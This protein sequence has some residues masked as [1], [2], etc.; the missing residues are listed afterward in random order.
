MI[1]RSDWPAALIILMY[2]VVG[3]FYAVYTPTW[4]VPD[5]PA[6]YNY[7]RSF[8]TGEGFPVMEAG[9]YDQAYLSRLTSEQFPE[10]LPV[11]P[12]EYE[13]H[14]PPLYYLLATPVF[15]LSGGAVGA[16]RL[17]SLLLG[18]GVIGMTMALV[19]EVFPKRPGLAWLAGGLV[20]FLPQ[21]VAMMAAVNN[22]ALT[23]LLLVSWLLLA[24][25]YLRGAVSP[26][27]LGVVLGLMFLTKTTG[28]GIALL[29][30]VAVALRWRRGG[31]SWKWAIAQT[32]SIL[33]PALL[34]GCL[35]WG[36]NLAVYGWPD[37]VGLLRHNEV[38]VGQPRTTE[39]LARQGI[40]PFFTE[41]LRTTFRSFW[42]QFGWMGVVLDSRIYL[43]VGLFSALVAWG[44]LWQLG[45][46]IR[47]GVD[48]LFRDALILLGASLLITTGLYLGYNLT[49]VQH[50]GRY[51][52]T[53][54]PALALAGALGLNRLAEKRLAVVTASLLLVLL[55]GIGLVGLLLGDVPYATLILIGVAAA[56]VLAAGLVPA[57]YVPL[58][59]GA[60]LM[61]LVAL[62][63]L[64]LFGFIVP[65]LG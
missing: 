32:A 22:D 20:A 44:A 6:H 33:G 34:L 57:R 21:H 47:N 24:L 31:F 46:G 19:R 18:A 2:L 17:F 59:G 37:F 39:F 23:E 36:R 48:P 55:I 64:C 58:L 28:Y 50:Q 14:Q 27:L 10:S 3:T 8:A 56:G 40:W 1:N 5:E 65:L 26:V 53:A 11:T 60:V 13:D 30:L 52:F 49:F 51:L 7:I 4:Q 41:A 45:E 12:L 62:D 15:L 35:W 54:L 43:G 16:L 9:D 61:G 42:G 25:R 38:V 63:F 29:A